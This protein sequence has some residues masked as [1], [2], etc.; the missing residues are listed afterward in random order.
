MEATL[1]TFQSI[2]HNAA[3]HAYARCKELHP[4][5]DSLE[6]D[7]VHPTVERADDGDEFVC[8]RLSWN[9]RMLDGTRLGITLA[10]TEDYLDIGTDWLGLNYSEVLVDR[11]QRWATAEPF[12]VPLF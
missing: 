12:V 11:L 6:F 4:A 10:S 3:E 7:L 2:G 9:A 8:Y 1:A 5:L